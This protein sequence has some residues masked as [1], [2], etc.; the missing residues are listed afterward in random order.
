MSDS[1]EQG[2]PNGL[3]AGAPQGSLLEPSETSAF[4]MGSTSPALRRLSTATQRHIGNRSQPKCSARLVA[5]G[6]QRGSGDCASPSVQDFP[7]S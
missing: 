2:T 1:S 3:V 7:A 6:T 4:K 5:V